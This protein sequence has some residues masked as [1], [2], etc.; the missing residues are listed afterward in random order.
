[1]RNASI[2]K[3]CELLPGE[4][5]FTQVAKILMTFPSCSHP[6][7]KSQFAKFLWTVCLPILEHMSLEAIW[8][9]TNCPRIHIRQIA[10]AW[11]PAQISCQFEKFQFPKRCYLNSEGSEMQNYR[12]E[13]IYKKGGQMQ[14]KET[15]TNKGW[16]LACGESSSKRDIRLE[17]PQLLQVLEKSKTRT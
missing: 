11:W 15:K 12:M 3:Y 16:S 2:L 5:L 9:I 17:F 6:G 1:M 13:S 10:K 7:G 8:N 14:L 4:K